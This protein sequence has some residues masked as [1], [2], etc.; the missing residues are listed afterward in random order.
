M[1]LGVLSLCPIKRKI[2]NEREIEKRR[3]LEDADLLYIDG[4]CGRQNAEIQKFDQETNVIIK[5]ILRE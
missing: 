2:L 4:G 3:A 1:V 5:R